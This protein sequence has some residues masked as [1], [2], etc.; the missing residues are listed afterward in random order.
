LLVLSCVTVS[1]ALTCVTGSVPSSSES[2]GLG[3][4]WGDSGV[5]SE[6]WVWVESVEDNRSRSGQFWRDALCIVLSICTVRQSRGPWAH[7]E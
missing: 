5:A 1:L 4:Y 6:S 2:Q 7:D 3:E